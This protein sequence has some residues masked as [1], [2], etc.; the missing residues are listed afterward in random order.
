[1]TNPLEPY[2]LIAY[3]DELKQRLNALA[4]ENAALRVE[5]DIAC[6]RVAALLPKATPEQ[7]AEFLKLIEAAKAGEATDFQSI[8][9]ELERDADRK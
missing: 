3:I 4:Q 8:I 5:R 7:E 1:M 9:V 2:D 6:A